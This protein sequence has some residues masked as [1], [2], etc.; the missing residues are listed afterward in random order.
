ML[1]SWYLIFTM[2]WNSISA[3]ACMTYETCLQFCVCVC[4]CVFYP[5]SFFPVTKSDCF[6]GGGVY[7]VCTKCSVASSCLDWC[8]S[9][10]IKVLRK[11]FSHRKFLEETEKMMQGTFPADLSWYNCNN[12]KTDVSRKLHLWNM[13]NMP[14]LICWLVLDFWD[15]TESF[16]YLCFSNI[17][18]KGLTNF[19]GGDVKWYINVL[20]KLCCWKRIQNA[21]Q[22][23]VNDELQDGEHVKHDDIVEE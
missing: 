5:F 20:C 7:T 16:F 8:S 15:S 10:T 11:T 9:K 12:I 23:Y 2:V 6:R 13:L 17:S 3:L 1:L 14:L 19:F 4:V 22:I 18:E 21:L